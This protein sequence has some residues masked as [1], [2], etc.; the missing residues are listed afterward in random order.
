MTPLNSIINTSQLS[1]TK[2]LSLF[3][4]IADKKEQL[5]SNLLEFENIMQQKDM[6]MKMITAV[7]Q[8]GIL[9]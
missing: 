8:S 9:L 1:G 5:S 4:F 7:H 2:M 3:D 6:S